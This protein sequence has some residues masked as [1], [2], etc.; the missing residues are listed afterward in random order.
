M[1]NQKMTNEKLKRAWRWLK[2]HSIIIGLSVG[3]VA[4]G[5]LSAWACRNLRPR[6]DGT[7]PHINLN[8][9]QRQLEQKIETWE[10]YLAETPAPRRRG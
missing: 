9:H 2:A 6:R 4:L 8:Q 10:R 5:L 3:A 1:R 7:V